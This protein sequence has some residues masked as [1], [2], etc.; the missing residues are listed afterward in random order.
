[1]KMFFFNV[2]KWTQNKLKNLTLEEWFVNIL[3]PKN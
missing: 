3:K 2:A 1:M